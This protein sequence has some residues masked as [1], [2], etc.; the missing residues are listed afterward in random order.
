M[1]SRAV[2]N[3]NSPLLL[4]QRHRE[5]I[6]DALVAVG[7]AV[8]VALFL[9]AA[10][11]AAGPWRTVL[12]LAIVGSGTYSR[13]L[14]YHVALAV[15]LWPLWA[16]SPYLALLLLAVALPLRGWLI[17]R[18]G[19]VLLIAGAPALAQWQVVGVV[20]LLAGLVAGPRTAL[21]VALFA[22][23]WLKMVG[24][25]A[26]WQPEMGALHGA[27]LSLAAIEARVAGASFPDTMR[28][29]A[30]PLT[31]SPLLHALQIAAWG[32]AGW[33][34]ATLRQ[35][36]W[37]E[38]RPQLPLVPVLATGVLVLWSA[39]FLL[40]V[41]FDSQSFFALLA[42]PTPT[43][44]LALSAILAALLSALYESVHHPVT[45]RA[46]RRAPAKPRAKKQMGRE[47]MRQARETNRTRAAARRHPWSDIPLPEDEEPALLS[48]E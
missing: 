38:G 39:L 46:K 5:R 9:N 22:A 2:V 33:L 47:G 45:T 17:E 20:P 19:W 1:A 34:V 4:Y 41:W 6:E 32:A 36:E 48:A 28:L 18:L 29:L 14:G 7:L 26:G 42:A 24:G 15:L 23:L 16:L 25:L 31:H 40:P 3:L 27:S 12:L 8:L 30:V 43:V 10:N 37:K 11:V 44:G 35:V 13:A 21:G